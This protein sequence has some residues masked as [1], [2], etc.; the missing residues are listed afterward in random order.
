MEA[1]ACTSK[2]QLHAS[3]Q[4]PMMLIMCLLLLPAAVGVDACAHAGKPQEAERLISWARERG[5]RP[6][7]GAYNRLLAHYAESGDMQG[8]RNV[9]RNLKERH[10]PDILTWNTLVAGYA[11]VGDI[12]RARAV[13]DDARR[14]GCQP[15]AWT[16]AALLN[17]SGLHLSSMLL[18]S[19]K[20]N[21]AGA[22]AGQ[23]SCSMTYAGFALNTKT[24]MSASKHG[25]D[26]MLFCHPTY[27]CRHVR[28]QVTCHRR[29]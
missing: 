19:V 14:S 28:K 4:F 6:G 2:D 15:D 21:V 13:I 10:T 17:V 27:V 8:A 18:L 12:S 24:R 29:S 25:A 5:I 23:Q 9:Y 22:A 20:G 11:R 26:L 16:W 1:A 7:L 3:M